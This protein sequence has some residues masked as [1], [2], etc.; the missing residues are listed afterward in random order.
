MKIY[1]VDFKF[2]NDVDLLDTVIYLFAKTVLKEE[3][4]LRERQVLKEYMISGYSKNTD[5]G[6]KIDLG[7]TKENLA[8][9]NS[10]LQKKGFLE[11]H[12]TNRNNR[13]ISPRLMELK[14]CFIENDGKKAYIIDFIRNEKV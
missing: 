6:I 13:L 10:R 4:C 12:P 8:T 1:K 9:L 2:N 5:R 14:S 11:K 3:V 7:I